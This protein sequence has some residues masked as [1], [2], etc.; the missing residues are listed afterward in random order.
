M[1]YQFIPVRMAKIKKHRKQQV[2]T[3]VWRKRNPHAL[4]VGMQTGIATVEASMEVP[5][6]N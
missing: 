4:L 2:L 3:R 6:K 5:Q 1:R